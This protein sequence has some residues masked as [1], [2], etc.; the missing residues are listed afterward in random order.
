MNGRDTSVSVII[1]TFNRSALVDRCIR[2]LVSA[3]AAG[4]EIVVVDDGGSDDTEAVVAGR[5]VYL[6]QSNA[7]PAAARNN[8]AAHSHGAFVAF[9]D[10]DD[11]WTPEGIGRLQA[12]MIAN[13]DV[14]VVFGDSLMG[15]DDDGFV[16]FV[17]TYGGEAFFALPGASRPDGLRVL[18]REIFFRQLSTRNVMFLGSMLIRRTFFDRISG[19]DP[20]LCGAADW[21]FFMRATA[22]GVVGYSDGSPVSKYYKHDAGMSTNSDHMEEDFIKALDSVRRRSALPPELLAHVNERLRGHVF[23]WAWLAWEKG[24]FRAARKRLRL[25]SALGQLG[26][27]EAAYL[28]GTYLPASLVSTLRRAR[29]AFSPDR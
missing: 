14:D 26:P 27:R 13:P 4:L 7:G 16:S 1:P 15:N 10:S 21:D 2:S 3:D 11:E 24:D 18:E 17:R 25:A 20:A 9:I 23:G 29:S 22:A 5:A 6:R 12:Q 8:G 28:A 19:F